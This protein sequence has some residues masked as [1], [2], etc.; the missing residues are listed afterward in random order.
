M[1]IKL[2]FSETSINML[3]KNLRQPKD[4]FTQIVVNLPD[5]LMSNKHS[6]NKKIH[7]MRCTLFLCDSNLISLI[8]QNLMFQLRL[9][10]FEKPEV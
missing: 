10:D 1:L 6:L 3:L 2:T 9:L 4:C 7:L 8:I 5:F